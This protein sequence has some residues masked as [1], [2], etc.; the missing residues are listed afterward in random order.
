MWKR[1]EGAQEEAD[2]MSIKLI[3]KAGVFRNV[4]EKY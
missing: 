2:E 3:K 4:S 1:F